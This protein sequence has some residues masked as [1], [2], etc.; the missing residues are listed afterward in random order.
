MHEIHCF[1]AKRHL[2]EKRALGIDGSF[3]HCTVISDTSSITQ[4]Q[5][6][7]LEFLSKES[8][9]RDSIDQS[10][11]F[12]GPFKRLIDSDGN[13]KGDVRFL[14]WENT[15]SSIAINYQCIKFLE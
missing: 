6:P 2:P 14:D 7:V 9:M 5:Y 13:A 3:T 1:H 10:V 12:R 15:K 4:A 11:S 8:Q